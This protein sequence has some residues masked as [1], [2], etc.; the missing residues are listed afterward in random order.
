MAGEQRVLELR[1]DG[2][3]VA[4][5]AG[6][7][8]LAGWMRA[9][10]L[11]RSS[12]LT[13]TDSQPDSRS[14]PSVA[15]RRHAR[16][17]YRA[18]PRSRPVL[19]GLRGRHRYASRLHGARRDRGAPRRRRRPA[20]RV[21]RRRLRRRG[22]EPIDGARP[23][24]LDARVRRRRRPAALPHARSTPRRRPTADRGLA[25]L[26]RP[27]LPR[28]RVAR[29]RLPRRHR[30]LLLP[31]HLRGHRPVAAPRR[32]H[33]RRR[34]R[35]RAADR[36]HGQAQPHRRVPALGLPRP[37]LEPRRHL[38][39]GARRDD[40]PGPHPRP[41]RAV[42]RGDGRARGRGCCAPR[43]TR[44]AARTVAR[45]THA[46]AT[47]T[48]S[49]SSRSPRAR[50]DVEWT[51]DVD[52]ARAV[53]AAGARRPAAPRR[54]TSRSWCRRATASHRRRSACAPGCARSQLRNW[55]CS[56]NGERLFLKGANQ[57]P[58]RMALA[59]ATPDELARDVDLANDAGLDLAAGPRAHHPARA[60]RRGR[61]GRPAALAG[62]PAAV[63]LRARHP[64]AGGA[65]GAR[66]RSTC[67]ATIRR[68]RSG[69][70]TTSRWRST[71]TRSASIE[72]GRRAGAR[73]APPRSCRPGTRRCSTARSSARSS[74]PTAPGR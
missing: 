43:S 7:E 27:L 47:S 4:E 9:I 57:G 24:A 33:A 35:V 71:S 36:P 5:D 10:A 14:W 40:R 39:A 62:P 32:A 63:G 11:R 23:L 8:R 56:V 17:T 48:T 65:P 58:T 55:I 19:R 53:V 42:P 72:R 6:E 74:R 54:R 18:R 15:G 30:G 41:P 22:W 73:A 68:S 66:P 69:A 44:D 28:R 46:S 50:T 34:G 16:P 12:S 38:A 26:R 60:L 25:A 61:R 67:S 49:P 52:R 3:L 13:G 70:G 37:R 29:R 31:A 21:R 45:R 1:E 51:V 2:V 64:Q 20:P 59:E